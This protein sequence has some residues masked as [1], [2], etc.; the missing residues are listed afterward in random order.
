MQF[1]EKFQK[2]GGLPGMAEG[3]SVSP[4]HTADGV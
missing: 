4:E 3:G 1:W 2:K